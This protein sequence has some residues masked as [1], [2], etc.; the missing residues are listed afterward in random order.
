MFASKDDVKKF[1]RERSLLIHKPFVVRRSSKTRFSVRCVNAICKFAMNFYA[2]SHGSFT[3]TSEV[4]HNCVCTSASTS[5]DQISE[6]LQQFLISFP[7]MTPKQ[8]KLK[9]QEDLKHQVNYSTLRRV[10]IQIRA[11]IVNKYSYVF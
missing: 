8:A 1:V 10:F 4:E 7:E 6:Y 3:L 9:I 5:T 2:Q 11:L